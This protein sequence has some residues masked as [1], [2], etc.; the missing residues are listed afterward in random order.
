MGSSVLLVTTLAALLVPLVFSSPAT[1]AWNDPLENSD[2]VYRLPTKIVPNDYDLYL[3]PAFTDE[4]SNFS[5]RVTINITVLERT[6]VIFVHSDNLDIDRTSTRVVSALNDTDV[7][8]ATQNYDAVRHFYILT[9]M[10]NLKTEDY[11]VTFHFRGNIND[12]LTGIYR[13]SYRDGNE[14]RWLVATQF[15]PSFARRA[16][17]CF[18]EPGFKATFNIRIAHYPDQVVLSNTQDSIVSLPN[19]SIGGRVVTQFER[20]LPISPYLVAFLV[21]DFQSVRMSNTEN[22]TFEIWSR[23]GT[24]DTAA[25]A[26]TTSVRIHQILSNLVGTSDPLS[27]IKQVAVPDFSP[28]GTENWGLI[29]YRERLLLWKEGESSSRDREL[30]T[31]FLARELAHN[32]FGNLVTPRWWDHLWFSEGF[33]TFY[34]NLVPSLTFPLWRFAERIIID[35]QLPA[36]IEDSFESTRPMTNAVGNPESVSASFDNIASGKS[37]AVIRMLN[38]L[39]R[40]DRFTTALGNFFSEASYGTFDPERLWYHMQKIA[41]RYSQWHTHISVAAVMNTWVN[42]AGYPLVTA[43]R[44]YTGTTAVFRQE[45]FFMNRRSPTAD[46][47]T[48]RWWIPITFAVG[49]LPKRCNGAFI[50]PD[51]LRAQDKEVIVAGVANTSWLMANCQGIGFYRTNYDER[52]WEMLT[53]FLKSPDFTIVNPMNRAILVDDSLNL[54]RAGYIDYPIALN[55][56]DY[57][58]Q[59]SDFVVWRAAIRPLRYL[60]T[61][62]SNF[63]NL[64]SWLFWQRELLGNVSQL[65]GW[66]A[67]PDDDHV[68]RIHRSQ[69]FDFACLIDKPGARDAAHRLFTKWIEDP[70]LY[71]VDPDLKAVVYCWGVR[72]ATEE[73]WDVMW[74]RFLAADLATEVDVLLRGLA[75]SSDPNILK[76]YLELSVT[77]NSGIRRQDALTVFTS[78]LNSGQDNVDTLLEFVVDNPKNITESYSGTNVV[79]S[80]LTGVASHVT[81]KDQFDKFQKFVTTNELA[82]GNDV[83]RNAIKTADENIRWI[84]ITAP[85]IENWLIEMGMILEAPT[86]TP[87]TTPEATNTTQETPATTQETPATTQETPAPGS[88]AGLSTNLFLIPISIF[89]IMSVCAIQ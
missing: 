79:G 14:T 65:T 54:A 73:T 20:T 87:L 26:L 39:M 83:V 71:A 11:L 60:N 44:N 70:R 74:N 34:Q 25:F 9:F 17:P 81:K 62:L 41:D 47:E 52:N 78:V 35:E 22:T 53:E 13:S 48:S 6:N 84:E 64:D 82:A 89:T 88:A 24:T 63:E 3:V 19:P 30:V 31:I 38:R 75:C 40:E 58:R 28:G 68:T 4:I 51:W 18:D 7:E 66:V 55:L 8:I 15:R 27:Q 45:R 67:D 33:S 76:K 1:F 16:F 5:G 46:K 85:V 86:S 43:T 32:F 59:E 10:E 37:A 69:I 21:S 80:I 57:L 2:I 36:L 42:Q 50:R 77:P 12:E 61:M 29:K 56:T 49:D 23:P 72:N